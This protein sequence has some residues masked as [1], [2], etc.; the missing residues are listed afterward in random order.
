MHVHRVHWKH[1]SRHSFQWDTDCTKKC[2]PI[3]IIKDTPCMTFVSI[4]TSFHSKILYS[5]F[6]TCTLVVDKYACLF[7]KI[8]NY[9]KFSIIKKL[10][11]IQNVI[12]AYLCWIDKRANSSIQYF[13]TCKYF[14]A[15]TIHLSKKDLY[16]YQQKFAFSKN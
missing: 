12:M 4:M 15:V 14:E 13:P 1:N 11:F 8:I 16:Y 2:S 10:S 9:F 3:S 6:S 5:S 7:F